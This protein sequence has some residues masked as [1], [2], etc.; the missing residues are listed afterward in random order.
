MYIHRERASYD[1]TDSIWDADTIT[2]NLKLSNP[3][4]KSTPLDV[5]ISMNYL[6]T[7]FR[8]ILGLYSCI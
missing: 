5:L 8:E 2:P 6:E 1:T 7:K 3:N 4:G